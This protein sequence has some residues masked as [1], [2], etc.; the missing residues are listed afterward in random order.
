MLT[1]M[2]HM[3]LNEVVIRPAGLKLKEASNNPGVANVPYIECGVF[4]TQL[5]LPMPLNQSPPQPQYQSDTLQSVL[6]KAKVPSNPIPT[7]IPKGLDQPLEKIFEALVASLAPS[8][9]H[10]CQK[11]STKKIVLPAFLS[12]PTRTY[13]NASSISCAHLCS[14]VLKFFWCKQKGCIKAAKNLCT[15][16][17]IEKDF[18]YQRLLRI[19]MRTILITDLTSMRRERFI[20]AEARLAQATAHTSVMKS[21]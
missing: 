7:E 16:M 20:E 9:I 14:P 15:F 18:S 10:T 11:H 2:S 17:W 21:V 8:T 3:D 12:H 13:P 1:A 5:T 19:I 4:G 6:C